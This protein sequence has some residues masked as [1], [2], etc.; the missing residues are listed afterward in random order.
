MGPQR[1]W[2]RCRRKP[3]EACCWLLREASPWPSSATPGQGLPAVVPAQVHER[4]EPKRCPYVHP[5]PRTLRRREGG[6]VGMTRGF[7]RV[8]LQAAVRLTGHCSSIPPDRWPSGYELRQP[9]LLPSASP[10]EQRALS[11]PGNSEKLKAMV[12][13]GWE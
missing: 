6:G 7:R 12:K 8:S 2:R 5:C 10:Q 11:W 1:Y 4:Q 9:V 13:Q 3:H